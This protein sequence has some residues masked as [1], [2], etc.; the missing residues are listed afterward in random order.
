MG[1]LFLL[2]RGF[3]WGWKTE[4][5]GGGCMLTI[6]NLPDRSLMVTVEGAAMLEEVALG[7]SKSGSRG[8]K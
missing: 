2:L 4:E 6:L 3:I 7:A 8:T 5:K 1:W